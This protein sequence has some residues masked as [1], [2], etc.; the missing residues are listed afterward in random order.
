[1]NDTA[2][3]V[4]RVINPSSAVII[5]AS[6]NP[7]SWG[8][9]MAEVLLE[10][11][12]GKAYL[13]NPSGDV[14]LGEPSFRRV[15]EIG[16]EIDLAVVAV[17]SSQI[18][19]AVEDCARAGVKG[20]VVIAPR[21]HPSDGETDADF[22]R[23]LREAA[24]SMRIVGPN[25]TG[26]DNP[27]IGLNTWGML[28]PSV[29]GSVAVITQSG[30]IGDHVLEQ[31]KRRG[32]GISF[33]VSVGNE[34]DIPI[35]EYL[36]Y[37]REDPSS[38]IIAL[39]M[40]GVK[41]GRRFL[42]EASLTTR[43]KPIVLLKTGMTETGA[44]AT[45]SHTGA[46]A[47]SAVVSEAAFRR[48]GIII[49]QDDDELTDVIEA[50]DK[51][52]VVHGDRVAI[53]TEGGGHGS[54]AA[55]LI[56]RQGLRAPLVSERTRRALREILVNQPLASTVNPVDIPGMSTDPGVLPLVAECLVESGEFDAML[57]VGEFGDYGSFWGSRNPELV[58]L[59]AAAAYALARVAERHDFPIVVHTIFAHRSSAA[60]DALR[61]SG[62]A[63][64]R[65]IYRAVRCL[66]AVG[67]A[68]RTRRTMTPFVAYSA[69]RPEPRLDH[70]LSS[71][72]S[73]GRSELDVHEA[74]RI[75][76]LTGLA[77][78]R[79]GAA[80]SAQEA[81]ELADRIGYPVVMKID[82]PDISHKSDAGGVMIGLQSRREVFEAF[83]RMMESVRTHSPG[84]RIEGVALFEMAKPGID[85]IVGALNDPE[86]GPVV[87]FGL[88]GVFVEV[89]GDVVFRVAPISRDEAVEMISEVGGYPLLTGA[90]GSA[91]RDVGAIAEVLVRISDLIAG[92][93]RI[94]EMDLNPIIAHERGVTVVD[95][96]VGLDGGRL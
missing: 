77:V 56:E 27:R 8:N 30:G 46:L 43:T 47:G 55:D 41:E 14:I 32:M 87:M 80:A 84:A 91:V 6:R 57:V 66:S 37:A 26:I 68:E 35:H 38:K 78:P 74:M 61:Q 42:E 89:L 19:G 93:P 51:T 31:F 75:A 81:T 21:P 82:S 13:V 86:F 79:A 39:Y 62:F 85:L 22:D 15:S 83:H 59:E 11:F 20:A 29:E 34:M 88:G 60:L 96:R 92:D 64:Y 76:E 50:L 95:A 67:N 58:E 72:L 25:C 9:R 5:G 90:R 53:V 45:A 28:E 24:G 52:P 33:Y 10:R 3:S 23:R 94:A 73:E 2:I 40:E 17:S 70:L 71:V 36:R 63:V 48:A 12:R 65:S 54:T 1:M 69:A 44:R 7:K 4:D 16:D 49:V 18:L